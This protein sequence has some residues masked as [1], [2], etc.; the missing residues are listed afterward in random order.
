MLASSYTPSFTVMPGITATL[1]SPQFNHVILA[2]PVDNDT[3][4]LEMDNTGPF[5]YT[6]LPTE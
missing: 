3:L 6:G 5:G 1:P 4:W 2:V